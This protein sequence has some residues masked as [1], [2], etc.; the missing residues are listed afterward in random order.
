MVSRSL[1]IS[2]SSSV[3]PEARESSEGH[4][5]DVVGLLFGEVK[6]RGHQGGARGGAVV[7]PADR[8]DHRRRACRSP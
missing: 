4:V 8:R 1:A 5:Q 2:S 3:R 6:G 7:G